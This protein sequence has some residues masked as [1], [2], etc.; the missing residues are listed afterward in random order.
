MRLSLTFKFDHFDLAIRQTVELIGNIL[1]REI[2]YFP[3]LIIRNENEKKGLKRKISEDTF[4][5]DM[6]FVHGVSGINGHVSP[7]KDSA[8]IASRISPNIAILRS[9]NQLEES[10]KV[11]SKI[12]CQSCGVDS[13]KRHLSTSKAFS[14]TNPIL[15]E[16]EGVFETSLIDVSSSFIHNQEHANSLATKD[17][18]GKLKQIL[19][20]RASRVSDLVTTAVSIQD[21]EQRCDF[22]CV[23]SSDDD[24]Q[25]K[26]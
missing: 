6:K 11:D 19:N 25:E 17:V 5:N 12:N 21:G 16:K 24:I 23:T 7:N 13:T 26:S 3:E 1:Y 9:N 22:I 15:N 10:M 8:G 14:E 20:D 2:S 18:I 4:E